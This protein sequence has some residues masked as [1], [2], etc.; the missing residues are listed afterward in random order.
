M[1][2]NACNKHHNYSCRSNKC[3]SINERDIKNWRCFII[4]F[5]KTFVF[6]Y[7]VQFIWH[8]KP[9]C[10][11]WLYRCLAKYVLNW[12][13]K[14]HWLLINNFDRMGGDVCSI[15]KIAH[16]LL[17]LCMYSQIA[18][19]RSKNMHWFEH[20]KIRRWTCFFARQR[21]TQGHLPLKYLEKFMGHYFFSHLLN[22]ITLCTVDRNFIRNTKSQ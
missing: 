16:G 9:S 11:T 5:Y 1:N 2:A 12:S 15:Y 8:W 10:Q 4:M 3:F 6:W 22:M 18:T 20:S 7:L 13:H 17:E 19:R 14:M 21:Y